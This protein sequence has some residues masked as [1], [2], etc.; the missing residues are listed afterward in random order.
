MS[1]MSNRLWSDQFLPEIQAIVG[2]HLLQPSPEPLDQHHATDLMMLDA[3]DMRVAARVRRP[4]YAH[5]YP[6]QF[7]LRS[8]LPSGAPTELGKIIEGK[9]DWLFYGH[10]SDRE[11]GLSNWW[12]IDLRAFRAGLIRSRRSGNPILC[13]S[14]LNPDGTS[15]MWFD[16]RSFPKEPPLVVAGAPLRSL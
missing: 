15:F 12:L 11:P 16:I 6:Y 9:G 7:T 5:R 1:Y 13:G 10:A 14:K 2:R 4:G 3:R 8:A